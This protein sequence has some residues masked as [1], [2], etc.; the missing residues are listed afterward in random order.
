MDRRLGAHILRLL[1][2]KDEQMP[3]EGA[4]FALHLI[5]SLDEVQSREWQ[6]AY[7]DLELL[8]G[9]GRSVPH[10]NLR[11]PCPRPYPHPRH[12]TPLISES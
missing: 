9:N 1:P 7:H 10:Q 11:E 2:G 8:P 3:V 12:L 5:I 4:F 6:Y